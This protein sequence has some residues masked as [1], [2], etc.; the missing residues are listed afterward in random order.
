MLTLAVLA[1]STLS[2]QAGWRA[3]KFN[4][5]DKNNDGKIG[6]V[7]AAKEK[8]WVQH[9][10]AKVNTPA[11][12]KMDRNHDGVVQPIEKAKAHTALYL[13]NRNDVDRPWEKY[14][15]KNNDGKVD[16][17]ELRAFHLVQLDANG[18][19]VIVLA[20]R[21]LYWA[22]KRAIVN[23][24]LERKYD[25]NGDGYLSWDEA[26]EYLRDRLRVIETDGRAIVNND[27]ETEFDADGDGILS[28]AEAAKLK[29]ALDE[30]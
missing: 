22:Q 8:K 2:T 12:A 16:A 18:D 7:E 17:V 5:A 26:R 30:V 1:G 20:E 11:E 29:A 4:H 6:P 9:Q 19:G 15:D 27:L 10:K 14:A 28:R 13:R 3:R 25:T 24:D 23:T 21:R